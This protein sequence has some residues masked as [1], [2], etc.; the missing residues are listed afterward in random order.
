M[1]KNLV[2]GT[3]VLTAMAFIGCGVVED[4]VDGEE[5]ALLEP[6]LPNCSKIINCCANLETNSLVPDAIKMECADTFSPAASRVI[7][8]YQDAR[9]QVDAD[10]DA[11]RE[12]Y[13]ETRSTVEP[14]CRCFLEET[15]GTVDDT[16]LPLDCEADTSVGD[17]VAMQCEGA[18]D[19]L[20]N[21]GN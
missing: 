7:S 10:S 11:A 6:D 4:I 1:S 18:V 17:A 15:V 3:L 5:T 8:T 12:L 20:V 16:L 13:D 21:T 9:G 19:D 14:G 2:F